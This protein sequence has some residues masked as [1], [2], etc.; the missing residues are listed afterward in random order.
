MTGIPTHDL[1]LW[2][3]SQGH[4]HGGETTHSVDR[5]HVPE[6][7]RFPSQGAALIP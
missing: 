1:S 6:S 3:D 2:L 4:H 5:G 7:F